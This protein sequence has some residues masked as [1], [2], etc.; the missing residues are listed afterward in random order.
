MSS[1]LPIEKALDH[2]ERAVAGL[3]S[4]TGIDA[5]RYIH[6]LGNEPGCSKH[7]AESAK[8]IAD[9]CSQAEVE[10][11]RSIEEMETEQDGE[12]E[13]SL[14]HALVHLDQIAETVESVNGETEAPVERRRATRGPDRRKRA[15]NA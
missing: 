13:E 2:L 5:L 11:L 8:H 6:R 3:T 14:G 9:L 15:A 10:L 12:A 7:A 4:S 1:V